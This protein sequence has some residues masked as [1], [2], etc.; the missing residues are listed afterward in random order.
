MIVSGGSL[1]DHVPIITCYRT[2]IIPTVPHNLRFPRTITTATTTSKQIRVNVPC[3]QDMLF[4]MYLKK[5]T[6]AVS[7]SRLIRKIIDVSGENTVKAI[8]KLYT[9]SGQFLPVHVA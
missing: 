6:Q 5:P 4:M 1:I 2:V 7:S 8:G 9:L 3:L